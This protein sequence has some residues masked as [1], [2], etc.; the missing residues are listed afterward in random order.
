MEI[1]RLKRDSGGG[2]GQ[3]ITPRTARHVSKSRSLTGRLLN[4][5]S[6]FRRVSDVESITIVLE[7]V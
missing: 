3:S 6:K 7:A 2:L 4:A 1:G 5:S